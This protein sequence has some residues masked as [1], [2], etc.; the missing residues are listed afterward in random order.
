MG[1][2]NLAMGLVTADQ[3]VAAAAGNNQSNGKAV[4]GN[5]QDSL[6]QNLISKI[7]ANKNITVD[8][9]T[10][11]AAVKDDTNGI[12]NIISELITG[13]VSSKGKAHGA[14]KNADET[15][16]SL[17][18]AITGA[19]TA[20]D[21]SANGDGSSLGAIQAAMLGL[22]GISSYLKEDKI[23]AQASKSGDEILSQLN[24]VIAAGGDSD[25]LSV[26]K[27]H[28]YFFYG[29]KKAGEIEAAPEAGTGNDTVNGIPADII[30][31]ETADGTGTDETAAEIAAAS[32]DESGKNL[33]A[34][35]SKSQ[36]DAGNQ[37]ISSVSNSEGLKAGF[38]DDSDSDSKINQ[39]DAD[40]QQIHHTGSVQK[41]SEAAV[42]AQSVDTVEP[43]RQIQTEILSKLEQ[44]GPSEFK[45][46]LQPE[47]LGQID[48]SLKLSDGKLVI[49][50]L[51][52]NS[53][54]Q[55][56]LAGQVD[57]LISSMGLQLQNVKVE[58]V[59]VGQQ[60]NYQNQDNQSQNQG[61][62]M[63]SGM[64]FSRGRQQEH[65]QNEFFRS[66]RSA[67]VLNSLFNSSQ[68]AEQIPDIKTLQFDSHRMNYAV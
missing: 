48:I 53:K 2:D 18:D 46:Q 63:N 15:V 58:S 68:A 57:K 55:E 23:L 41:S 24:A 51:A 1:I 7:L 11:G 52:A 12:G 50:I 31:K 6:F 40:L 37:N 29:N 56:L 30:G 66:G 17:A 49:D 47:N 62:N 36:M 39:A 59:Q 5:P 42:D 35:A 21:T 61:F 65:F 27:N 32:T 44:K 4:Q 13:S 45:M 25:D 67:E 26:L 64:D 60:T 54:T 10:G 38:K 19:D 14:G 43:Y 9:T 34:K 3:S 28:K 16:E 22:S 33:F 20:G 8:P